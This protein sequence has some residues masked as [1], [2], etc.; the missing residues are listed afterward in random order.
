MK[1][2]LLIV[3]DNFPFEV[4]EYSFVKTELEVLLEHFEISILSLA[5]S[6]E[7]PKIAI[8]KRIQLYHCIRKF[9]IREKIEIVIK[10]LLSKYGRSEIREI[11]K[12]GQNIVG[13]LYD[14]IVYFGSADQV[15]KYVRRNHVL[16]GDELVYSYWFNANC[17]AF[18]MDKKI[19]PNLKVVSRIHR[20]DLYNEATAHNRQPFRKYMDALTDKIFFV[21]DAGLQYY[22]EQWGNV[23]NLE[24]KYIIAPIGTP[25]N[26]YDKKSVFTASNRPMHIVSCSNVIPLKRVSL[27]IDGLAQISEMDI[28]WTHFGT[29][30]LLDETKKY[31][32]KLLSGKNNISYE[33]TGYVPVEE[34]MQF[35]E[36]NNIDCFLTTS[37][38]EGCPVSIQEAMSY[39][40]PIIGTAVGEIPNMIDGNGILLPENPLPKDVK[41]AINQLYTSAEDEILN[42]R[43]QSRALWEKQYNAMKNADMFA[44]E[45]EKVL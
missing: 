45:L 44:K 21:A 37:S 10:Y 2:R 19:Y 28:V 9:G 39:G 18:L 41:E 24:N 27:I 3:F 40:I 23:E 38:S 35:Y 7:E 5:D 11:L 32:E 13:R 36:D 8:D 6:S 15:R 42:T 20:Y 33:F 4:G 29:G 16:S 1:K 26:Q 25:D 17:L 30:N 22:M 43:E 34:I 14:S 12:S 31:A